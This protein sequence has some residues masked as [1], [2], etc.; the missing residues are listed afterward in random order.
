MLLHK[1][2]FVF[3]FVYPW[4]AFGFN[5]WCATRCIVLCVNLTLLT[6]VWNKVWCPSQ[7][8]TALRSVRYG[9]DCWTAS[10]VVILYSIRLVRF[11]IILLILKA[12]K[13]TDTRIQRCKPFVTVQLLLEISIDLLSCDVF[14]SCFVFQVLFKEATVILCSFRILC[15]RFCSRDPHVVLCSCFSVAAIQ[16]SWSSKA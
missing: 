16:L 3:R 9:F 7:Y 2:V 12:T 15:S 10:T 8:R 5:L 4:R 6:E 14:I 13:K 1:Y 11:I